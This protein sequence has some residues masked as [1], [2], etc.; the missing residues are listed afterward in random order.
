MRRFFFVLFAVSCGGD[1][2]SCSMIPLA[3][4]ADAGTPTQSPIPESLAKCQGLAGELSR[5][6]ICYCRLHV[7]CSAAQRCPDT[8][9]FG[10]DRAYP[11]GRGCMEDER[12]VKTC[13]TE[14]AVPQFDPSRVL[15]CMNV[16]D[17]DP[18]SYLT[19]VNITFGKWNVCTNL[20]MERP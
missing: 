8:I 11:D 20:P 12:A 4:V 7:M 9:L 13:E 18:C 3:P 19:S 5:R 1:G 15:S 14:F 6:D 17:D 2:D 16:L 10:L